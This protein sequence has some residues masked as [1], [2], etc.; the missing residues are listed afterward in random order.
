MHFGSLRFTVCSCAFYKAVNLCSLMLQMIMA[1][2][3]HLR[4]ELTQ[5]IISSQ[6]FQSRTFALLL[7]DPTA[8]LFI[9]KIAFEFILVEVHT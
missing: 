5:I 3:D 2:I 4:L 6:V 7:P 8:V 1:F 9:L